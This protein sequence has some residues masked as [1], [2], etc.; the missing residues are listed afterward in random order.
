M[1]FYLHEGATRLSLTDRTA[2]EFPNEGDWFTHLR[3]CDVILWV[4]I[5]LEAELTAKGL[6]DGDEVPAELFIAASVS[7]TEED[8]FTIS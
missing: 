3:E 7:H 6:S 5:A 2:T 4:S 1:K 8:N